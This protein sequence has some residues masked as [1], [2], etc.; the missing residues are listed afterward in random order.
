MTA[1]E[2]ERTGRMLTNFFYQLEKVIVENCALKRVLQ[3]SAH[4]NDPSAPPLPEQVLQRIPEV[5]DAVHRKLAAVREK[6]LQALREG[7]IPELPDL[8]GSATNSAN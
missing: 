1:E 4:P 5:H 7:R 6:I 2:I 8:A 3:E